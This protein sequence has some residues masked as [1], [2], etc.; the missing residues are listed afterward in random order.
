MK[1]LREIVKAYDEAIRAGKKTALAAV[2]HLNGSSYRRPGARMLVTDDG[3]LTGAIS[4]GCLEGDALRKAMLVLAQQQP[5]L[6]TYDTTDEDD[7]TIGIQL[8]CAGIIQVLFEPVD[9]NNHNNPIQLLRKMIA[10]RQ[11]SVMVTLFSLEDKKNEQAGTCLLL[12]ENGNISGTIPYPELH[13]AI[14]KDVHEA[15]Q[16]QSSFFKN[17]A[18]EK[19][20]VSA[21]IEFLQPSVS[22]VVV[23]AGNDAIPMMQIAG[24]IGWEVRVVDGRSTYARP[25][26]FASACQVLV[27]KPEKALDQIPVDE[28]TV[29]VMMTHNYNYDLAMLKILLQRNVKYI[30]LL[31]PR[32]KLDRMLDELHREGMQLSGAQLNTIY[33]PVGLEIGAE[34]AEEIALSIIAEIKAVLAGKSGG[35]LRNKQDVIHPETDAFR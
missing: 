11:K 21:F 7:A 16:K 9:P 28:Q 2:V 6:V 24:A 14:M 33:G 23:G 17:Y 30:G 10:L 34:T 22:L 5:K 32:K 3:G 19:K 8:G 1:E 4:G 18:G 27:S 12:E 31:G 29:F 25:E 15:M 35:S 20:S 13:D 26:R